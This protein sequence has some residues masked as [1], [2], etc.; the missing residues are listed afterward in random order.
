T[1]LVVSADDQDVTR[2]VRYESSQPAVATVDATG[3][4]V[5][6]GVGEATIR[7]VRG[8]QTATVPVSVKAFN[9]A[10]RI[11]FS[12]EIVPLMTRF[13]C[14]AGG[15]HGKASGQNGFKLSLFGFDPR[16][17]Y[18]AIVTEA[19]GRRVFP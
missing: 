7:I 14:N 15:C 9:R 8:E 13:G 5:P 2:T 16:F 19:R 18:Q 4:V 10:R 6:V 17:D 1:Q 3:L 12:T 11:D